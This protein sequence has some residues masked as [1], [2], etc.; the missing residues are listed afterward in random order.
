MTRLTVSIV[1][2]PEPTDVSDLLWIFTE[3]EYT[4]EQTGLT[5]LHLYTKEKVVSIQWG[6][7]NYCHSR[8]L[9]W[10]NGYHPVGA[11]YCPDAEVWIW[12]L[13][14]GHSFLPEGWEH[15]I[16]GW[17]PVAEVLRIVE[18]L[19]GESNESSRPTVHCQLDPVDSRR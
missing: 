17:V 6:P 16:R 7:T 3:R 18:Y 10:S 1:E 4:F 8:T 19:V 14:S 15:P 11:I 13:E 9:K 2:F 5:G 12:D